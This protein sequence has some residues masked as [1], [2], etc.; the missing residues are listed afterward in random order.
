MAEALSQELVP[1]SEAGMVLSRPPDLVLREAHE[2]AAALMQVMASKKRKLIFNDE[3]YLE[4]EDWQTVGRFYGIAPR[5]VL[6]RA[7]E[8]GEVRG[9]EASA[10]AVHVASG[11]VVSSADA[12]CL[13]DEDKWRARSKYEYHYVKKS[14]GTSAE[15]PGRDEL[16]WERGRDGKNR[17][18]KERVLVGDEAVPMF[19]LRSMAQTRAGAKALRNAL[20]WVVVL[21]GFK[22]TPAE[23][24]PEAKEVVAEIVPSP[25]STESQAERLFPDYKPEEPAQA[26]SGTGGV[27]LATERSL[28]LSKINEWRTKRGV[29]EARFAE[30]CKAEGLT[31]AG[32]GNADPAALHNLLNAVIKEKK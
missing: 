32:L 27:D 31:V 19:Q 7:V 23:E 29:S 26:A 3:Q 11:R 2:A 16:I 13:N 6:T 1:V 20:A 8:Y 12:M 28:Y 4:F 30:L 22:P 14:G 18:K 17:P 10:E 5:I 24:M 21:A 15:D 9:W 25:E